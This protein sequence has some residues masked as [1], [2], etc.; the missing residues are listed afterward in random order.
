M[1]VARGLRGCCGDR[2]KVV[3]GCCEGARRAPPRASLLPLLRHPSCAHPTRPH[4]PG[5]RLFSRAVAA[6]DAGASK[7]A[8]DSRSGTYETSTD[9]VEDH[10]GGT[11]C[12]YSPGDYV[13]G[14]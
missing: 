12:G 13:R 4:A 10:G 6:G 11:I 14:G 1:C 7:A 2:R 9:A 8:H 5:A 3:L